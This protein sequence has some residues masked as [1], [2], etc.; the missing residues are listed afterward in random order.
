MNKSERK[1][2]QW[3]LKQGIPVKAIVY[4]S[5]PKSPDFIF[6]DRDVKYEVKRL[7]GKKIL[8]RRE[9]FARL[10]EMSNVE[11]L[12]FSDEG[13]EPVAIIPVKDIEE[14]TERAEGLILHWVPAEPGLARTAHTV[15]LDVEDLEFL[16]EKSVETGRS[17]STLIRE[18]VK[19]WIREEKAK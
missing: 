5:Q 8:L 2:F 4:Q 19:K 7:Y 11:I 10:K 9:Q 12:V 17:L 16:K 1:A 6:T 14:G 13:V 15:F 18:S 3:L